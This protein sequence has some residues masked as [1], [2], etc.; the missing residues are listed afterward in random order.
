MSSLFFLKKLIDNI[1]ISC[2]TIGNIFNLDG[3]LLQEQYVS[4]ISNFPSW[5][6]EHQDKNHI[7]F[8]DNIGTHLSIDE[9]EISQ[10]ELYTVLTNKAGKGKTGTLVAMIKGT[11]TELI[12]QV[13]NQISIHKRRKVKEVTCDLAHNMQN[14]IKTSFPKASTVI[15]RFH[16]QKLAL[17]AVQEIRIKHR[18]LA[19]EQENNEIQLAKEQKQKYKPEIL[20]NGDTLKQLLAR[21]R[22]ILFKP[23][24]KWTPNQLFRAEILFERYPEIEQAYELSQELRKVYQNSKSKGVAFTK[25]AQW[26]NKVE[27]A[28]FKSFNTI[29]QTIQNHYSQ[30]LNYF[31][32]RSTNASAESF[33]AK[34]KALRNQ[35]RGIKNMSFFLFRLSKIYG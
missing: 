28:G 15:D 1:A 29:S 4:H 7:L 5:Y 18:W 35:F 25:L 24:V 34:I 16:V 27:L 10:G 8:P 33:N 26:Y 32:L 2:K 31:D 3:K 12:T 11:K 23:K 30:I 21:S 19:L 13:I 22:H 9:T 17:E 20:E 14:I 6:L